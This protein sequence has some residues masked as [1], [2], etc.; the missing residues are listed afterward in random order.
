MGMVRLL[1][2][3]VITGATGAITEFRRQERCWLR[4]PC[5]S[6][7]GLVGTGVKEFPGDADD[8]RNPK[9]VQKSAIYI[10][11]YIQAIIHILILLLHI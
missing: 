7:A 5:V 4:D 10:Y 8:V 11:I 3:M 6:T 2:F 9:N 1:I